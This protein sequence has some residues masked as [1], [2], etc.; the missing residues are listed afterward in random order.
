MQGR[1]IVELSTDVPRLLAITQTLAAISLAVTVRSAR[2]TF[3][4]Q[5]CGLLIKWLLDVTMRRHWNNFKDGASTI[6][7]V[8]CEEFCHE[9]Q[10]E[11]GVTEDEF[12]CGGVQEL[13]MYDDDEEM[14]EIG[15]EEYVSAEE[16]VEMSASELGTSYRSTTSSSSSLTIRQRTTPESTADAISG[17]QDS[18]KMLRLDWFLVLELRTW[19]EVRVGLRELYISTLVVNPDFKK[20][21]GMLNL[22]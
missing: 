1:D 9:R 18:Q 14:Q 8:I 16:D 2:D 4:E 17:Y 5:T 10:A 12:D 13:A 15:E 11:W 20:V 3:R 21:L 19:K 6:R 7:D 22:A